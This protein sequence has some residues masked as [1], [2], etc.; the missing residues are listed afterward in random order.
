M[1]ALGGLLSFC[2]RIEQVL[3]MLLS[4][5]NQRYLLLSY[6]SSWLS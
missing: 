4:R 5:V 2:T 3:L 1:I 6:S